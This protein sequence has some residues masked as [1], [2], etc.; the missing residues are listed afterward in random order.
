MLFVR[1]F[2]KK[3]KIEKKKKTEDY[4]DLE[5]VTSCGKI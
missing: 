3:K 2:I 1:E 5:H 4:C